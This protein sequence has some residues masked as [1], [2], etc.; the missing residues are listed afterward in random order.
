MRSQFCIGSTASFEKI[1][2]ALTNRSATKQTFSFSKSNRFD[3]AKPAYIDLHF[4]CPLNTYNGDFI[5]RK[6]SAT[7]IGYGTRSDFTKCLSVSPASGKYNLK[8]FWDD[9]VSKKKGPQF[10]LSRDVLQPLLSKWPSIATST[11]NNW[12]SPPPRSTTTTSRSRELPLSTHLGRR[13]GCWT[14]P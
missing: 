1:N 3:D 12:P 7:G 9:G 2:K 10:A 6:P 13:R 4:R 8:S 14:S 11:R 5:K